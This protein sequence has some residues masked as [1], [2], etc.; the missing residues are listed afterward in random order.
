[1]ADQAAEPTLKAKIASKIGTR[2]KPAIERGRGDSMM[3]TTQES[4]ALLWH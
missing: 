1:M 3:A 2:P 4:S